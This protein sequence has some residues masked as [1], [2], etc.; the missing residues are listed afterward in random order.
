MVFFNQ[1]GDIKIELN[2]EL[3]IDVYKWLKTAVFLDVGNV[4]L[5]NNDPQ[6]PNANFALNRFWNEFAM[7]F[8]AGVRLD[9]SYFVIRLDYGV[10]IRDPR[11]HSDNKWFIKAGQ[12]QLGVGY[13]F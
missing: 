2:A 9:F 4:W 7:N 3:R 11:I 10:P 8:G 5:L 1:T 13:P 12:F 6:R